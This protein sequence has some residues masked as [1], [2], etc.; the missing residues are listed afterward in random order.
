MGREA[1]YTE[2]QADSKQGRALIWSAAAERSGDAALG[3]RVETGE[4]V[5]NPTRLLPL[6]IFFRSEISN[7][8]SQ[9]LKE[10]PKR[11][12]RLT[13]VLLNLK[14]TR[15]VLSVTLLIHSCLFNEA[16]PMRYTAE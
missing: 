7:F 2:E 1:E 8:R 5:G 15:E 10:N 16:T 12:D 14:P 6:W 11:G 9:M 13:A 3:R 4:R